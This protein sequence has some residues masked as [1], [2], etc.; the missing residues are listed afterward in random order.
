MSTKFDVVVE[1]IEQA[2]NLGMMPVDE[3]MRSL[4]FH[5]E[6]IERN[7]DSSIETTFK[8][9]VI[10]SR[11][12]DQGRGRYRGNGQ[13]GR[14]SGQR[15][16]KGEINKKVEEIVKVFNNNQGVNKSKMRCYSCNKFGNYAHD[17]R[18]RIDDRGKKRENVTT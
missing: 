13:G 14:N 5:E 18:K 11:D 12:K 4:L 2:K 7:T 1:T 9:Q 16:G 10:I 17:S 6:R 15:D 8:I 3:L